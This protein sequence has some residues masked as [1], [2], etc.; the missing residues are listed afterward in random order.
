[1]VKTHEMASTLSSQCPS[2]DTNI[3]QDS[4]SISSSD[5]SI[6]TNPTDSNIGIENGLYNNVSESQLNLSLVNGDLSYDEL[7]SSVIPICLENYKLKETIKKNNEV[8]SSQFETMVK[9]KDHIETIVKDQIEKR[10]QAKKC[11]EELRL[12]NSALKDDLVRTREEKVSEYENQIRDLKN[13]NENNEILYHQLK[14]DN[15]ELL[16]D[17]N[18][19]KVSYDEIMSEKS[20][21]LADYVELKHKLEAIE[22]SK[23]GC[24]GD[25]SFQMVNNEM[26]EGSSSG[27]GS[28]EIGTSVVPV[29]PSVSRTS[30]IAINS[31]DDYDDNS[32]FSL[33][34]AERS[35]KHLLTELSSEHGKVT[36]LQLQL[37]SEKAKNDSLKKLVSE[38]KD[39]IDQLSQQSSK[40]E[41][42]AED[43]VKF[44][45]ANSYIQKYKDRCDSLDTWLNVYQGKLD[46]IQNEDSDVINKLREEV[47]N[48]RKILEDERQCSEEDKKQLLEERLKNAT[49]MEE[50]QQ[51][52][53]TWETM[54]HEDQNQGSQTEA[55]YC[56]QLKAYQERE[57]LIHAKLVL[58][59]EKLR[60]KEDELAGTHTEVLK[61]KIE[62][63]NLP[64]LQTQLEVYKTDFQEERRARE[65]A[66]EHSESLMAEINRLKGERACQTSSTV[67]MHDV[68]GWTIADPAAGNV[69]ENNEEHVGGVPDAEGLSYTC[70]KCNFV[71]DGFQPLLNHVNN[72]LDNE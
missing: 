42:S 46:T 67:R 35:I 20:M 65:A 18:Q 27:S 50:H 30:L 15:D 61:L 26:F 12:E 34:S 55:Y 9:T 1:M 68:E 21:I 70:P 45:V 48:L 24:F 13:V 31:D 28:N 16:A 36:D 3:N 54:F 19:L 22:S 6:L 40:T 58:L 51:L 29:K 66:H 72:C 7:Q 4:D 8:M 11:I 71:F 33:Q 52:K 59:E 17:Y 23:N 64:L 63:E 44:S 69:G 10:D 56:L 41:Q 32:R 37:D 38:Q 60:D 47:Q 2:T 39:M 25:A 53:N 5:F 57:D 43:N 62:L 14:A 49:L